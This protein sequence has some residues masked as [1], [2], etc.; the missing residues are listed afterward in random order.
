MGEVERRVDGQATEQAT[1]QEVKKA[2]VERIPWHPKLADLTLDG[3]A[4]VVR[5]TR[6]VATLMIN[7]ATEDVLISDTEIRQTKSIYVRRELIA[8]KITSWEWFFGTWQ[9]LP[10]RLALEE[11]C[12]VLHTSPAW[13]REKVIAAAKPTRYKMPPGC[14]SELLSEE[15]EDRVRR[16]ILDAPEVED[17]LLKAP[18]DR[19][20]EAK[21]LVESFDRGPKTP[22]LS[23]IDEIAQ[24]LRVGFDL[25]GEI[26][27]GIQINRK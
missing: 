11:V 23:P 9:G 3:I 18:Q 6:K 27:S 24:T 15:R 10:P 20:E 19:V 12:P 13:I 21:L 5:R 1:E 16:K 4:E 25:L 2:L 7:S 22:A 8:S 17:R 26:D 14:R